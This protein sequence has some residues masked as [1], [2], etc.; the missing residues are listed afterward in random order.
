MALSL[1]Q[2]V[3][4]HDV[5]VKYIGCH[6]DT[7][8]TSACP[9]T[10]ENS[11]FGASEETVFPLTLIQISETVI[12]DRFC[13][14]H[15]SEGWYDALD[16]HFKWL[17]QYRISP[18]FCRWG[19]SMRILA[20]TCP[21]PGS[22]FMLN[23]HFSY[24]EVSFSVFTFLFIFT[25]LG[26]CTMHKIFLFSFFFVSFAFSA[27]HPRADEYYSDPR[28]AAYAVPYTPILS[29]Y[30][31]SSLFLLSSVGWFYDV[32]ICTFTCN[33][34][35]SAKV[36]LQKEVEILKSKDH[37]RKAYFYLWDE[38]YKCYSKIHYF[39][40]YAL[41]VVSLISQNIIN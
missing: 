8:R 31:S 21:W 11:Q 40:Y 20:Y 30:A 24:I 7:I 19:D 22:A 12:E 18:F 2:R 33:S 37:W 6:N 16:H 10:D 26:C 34:T 14:E 3:Q 13:L 39:V 36:A 17:L 35:D 32:K 28:L 9:I 4:S 23:E 1:Y 5:L 27:D 25:Q 29:W 38:V 15:G 41:S